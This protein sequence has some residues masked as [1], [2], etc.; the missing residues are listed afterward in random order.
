MRWLVA[1]LLLAP[2]VA[3]AH[4]SSDAFLTLAVDGNRV[5]GRWELALRDAA[6]L[7]RLDADSDGA[8][9][10]GELRAGEAALRAAL[11]SG[12]TV[13]GAEGPCALA[14][15]DILVNDRSDGRYAWLPLTA[16]CASAPATL[17]IGYRVL[18][19]IDP[20]HRAFLTV[21]AGSATHSAV[22][23]P[24][25]VT[26]SLELA[27]SDLVRVFIEYLKEGVHHIWIGLDHVLFLLA[28]LLPCVL[29]RAGNRWLP[30]PAL[31]PVLWSV[32][33]VVTAFTLAHSVTLSLAALGLMRLPTA[34]VEAV[35]ALSVLL[36]ALNNVRPLVTRARWGVAFGFGLVHGFGFAS[37]LGEL[38]LPTGARV[39]ALLAF[40]VGVE[41][42]QMAIVVVAVPLAYAFAR[43]RAYPVV[44]TAG[45]LLVALLAFWWL[46]LR[47]GIVAE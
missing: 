29:R 10:W 35:I 36:V 2:A 37:V 18:F 11:A 27:E 30:Q 17:R 41:L 6:L 3:G 25:R 1:V 15:G 44:L 31:R 26:T 22:F 24:D 40:N 13:A 34:A 38:G 4:R 7:A 14:M 39:L 19:D 33:G 12:L 43:T 32:L 23:A 20:T 28:L 42:G 5:E 16:D 47:V 45:S 9:T 21:A 46:L 8:L